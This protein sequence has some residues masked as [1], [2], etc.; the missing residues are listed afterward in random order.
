M[1]AKLWIVCLFAL[2][3]VLTCAGALPS[4]E[5]LRFDRYGG[6]LN[7]TIPTAGWFRVARLQGRWWLVDPEGHRFLSI[8]VN[9]VSY[10]PDTIQGTDQSPYR[11]AVSERYGGREAWAKA[12]VKRL[13]GWGFNTIGAWSDDLTWH[14]QMPYT[15]ILHLAE[16]VRTPEGNTFP[17]VF[18]PAYER[19][20]MGAAR[21]AC[22]PLAGDPWLVG[23]FTDNELRWGPDWRSSQTLFAEFLA[24]GDNA[25]G[26]QAVLRF[27][28]GRY[29]TIAGL[30][31]AWGT[32]YADFAEIGRT[33]QPAAHLPQADE[34][35][36][37]RLVA[38]R[39]FDIAQ[40]AV[41]AVDDHH[42]IL[43]CR[44][45]GYAPRPVLEAMR[46]HVDLVSFNH[47][48]VSPPEALLRQITDVTG[49][50]IIISEFSYRGRDSG[51]PNTRGAGVVVD[52]QRDRAEHFERYV[53]EL[54]T[55]PNAVGYH[56]FEHADEPAEG[57]FD[58]ENSN[59]GLVNIQ[60]QPYA[61]LVETMT[62]ANPA[63]FTAAS[64]PLRPQ[65]SSEPE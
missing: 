24:L 31:E 3:L 40:R 61:V 13:R 23:Y 41:R 29:R 7:G 4:K 39:Y 21:R 18:D 9:N 55:L 33:P 65:P 11:D 57:R 64:A 53:R 54:M 32:G 16:Q 48:D 17:D 26:R 2:C 38:E 27:L 51:L 25:T 63:A 37:L 44:F 45:A 36:F 34:D 28:E 47:Y 49:R 12:V 35:D 15:V 43:G 5:S 62:R 14:Q 20:A 42:M 1:P 59:Y 22:R 50:P 10:T 58:G 30:N 8:G 60:D 6:L 52:T 19:A 46:G 56:W